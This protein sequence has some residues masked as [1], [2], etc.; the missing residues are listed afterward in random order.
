M[1]PS[2]WA[3][4]QATDVTMK[5]HQRVWVTMRQV[6]DFLLLDTVRI[7]T[8]RILTVRIREN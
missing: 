7:I 2:D 1:G 6:E 4:D 5:V 8:V 3:L